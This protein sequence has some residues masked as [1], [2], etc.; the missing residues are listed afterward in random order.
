MNLPDRIS[1]AL[2]ARCD[3]HRAG[4][5]RT[6]KNWLLREADDIGE[7]ID[8]FRNWY[9]GDNAPSTP[10]LEKLI[11]K[12]GSAFRNE[13]FPCDDESDHTTILAETAIELDALARK[14]RGE[15]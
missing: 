10:A 1:S 2:Q 7:E 11:R 6:V 5:D 8:T 15:G 12:Y 3:A 13:I 9:Y 14:M 4:T